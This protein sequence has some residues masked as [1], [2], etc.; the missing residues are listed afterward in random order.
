[1]R[2]AGVDY[3]L[4]VVVEVSLEE[5][6]DPRYHQFLLV[7][8]GVQVAC[9]LLEQHYWVVEQFFFC[10][11]VHEVV[12]SAENGIILYAVAEVLNCGG[13]HFFISE[14]YGETDEVEL[15]TSVN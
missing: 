2:Y 15:P 9:V 13:F 5:V 3:F 12:A 7:T 10:G 4:G 1:M 6:A 14:E 11:L 8:L